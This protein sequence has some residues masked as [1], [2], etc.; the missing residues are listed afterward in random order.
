MTGCGTA[1]TPADSTTAVPAAAA[2]PSG[3]RFIEEE[4]SFPVNGMTVHGTWRHPARQGKPA[5]A[6]LL[7]AGSGPTDRNGNAPQLGGMDTLKTMAELLSVEGVASLRYDKLG[8]GKTGLGPYAS[9]AADVGVGAFEREATAAL[10]FLAR[11]PG[12]DERRLTVIGHSEGALFALL[13]ATK[14]TTPVHSLGLLEPL[15]RRYLDVISAQIT[16]QIRAQLQAGLITKAQATE[17]EDAMAKAVA[18]LRADGTVP[19]NLPGGLSNLLSPANAKYLS[20]ADRLNPPELAAG[21]KARTPVLL[22]CSDA[23]IQVSCD[24]VEHLA[25]GLE[26]APADT[27]LVRLTGVSHVLKEDPS[28]TTNRYGDPLPFSSRLTQALQAFVSRA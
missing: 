14:A 20:E 11:R 6:V 9:K 12:V 3:T 16:A 13:L 8:S 26:K 28:R 15:S 22:S 23:D 17:I 19:A 2:S 1:A 25:A 24:E 18:S 7:I 27:D 5:P 10:S 21:L 4:V